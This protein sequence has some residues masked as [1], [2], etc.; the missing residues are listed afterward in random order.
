MR[1]AFVLAGVG[2]L[3]L[4]CVPRGDPP[5]G[6]Q[7]LADRISLPLAILPSAGDGVTRIL[8]A[9]PGEGDGSMDLHVL[10]VDAAGNAPV[11]HLLAAGVVADPYG[12]CQFGAAGCLQTDARGR[13]LLFSGTAFSG[14]GTSLARIDPVTG[15]RMELGAVS[16]YKLSPSGQRLLVYPRAQD[17]PSTLFEADD[18]AVPLDTNGGQFGGEVLYYVTKQREATRLAPGGTPEVLATGVDGVSPLAVDGD[19]LVMLIRATADRYVSNY[20]LLDTATL[21]ETPLAVNTSAIDLSR[22]GRWL[23]TSDIVT[24]A[25]TFTDWRSGA[26]DVFRPPSWVPVYGYQWR[27]GHVEMWF[28]NGPG[29]PATTWIKQPGLAPVE[30]PGVGAMPLFT[31]DGAYWFSLKGVTYNEGIMIGAA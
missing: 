10:S 13:L 4:A 8:F 11:E 17:A 12:G 25:I 9:R 31:G 20:A 23:V 22:D 26:Q 7:V 1:R 30:I 6:R 21:Q 5:S 18:R 2:V 27:P 3:A 14:T 16:G 28:P 15:D 19:P 24:G 29:G